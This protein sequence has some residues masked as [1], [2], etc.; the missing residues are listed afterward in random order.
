V[1]SA[2][3][4]NN[5]LRILGSHMTEPGTLIGCLGCGGVWNQTWPSSVRIWRILKPS[6]IFNIIL[7]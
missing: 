6:H 2:A 3:V 5:S 1:T 4:V 7:Q